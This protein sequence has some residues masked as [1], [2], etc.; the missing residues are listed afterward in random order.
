MDD[1]N[2]VRRIA[3]HEIGMVLDTLSIGELE[4]RI[5]FLEGE[6]ERLKSAISQKKASKDAADSVFKFR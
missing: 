1:D 3:A 2:E 4:E 6:I 5:G